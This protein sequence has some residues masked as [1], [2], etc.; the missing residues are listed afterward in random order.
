MAS[1]A[2]KRTKRKP[3][4]SVLVFLDGGDFFL[5][6]GESAE[7]DGFTRGGLLLELFF[8]FACFCLVC[9]QKCSVLDLKSKHYNKNR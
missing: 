3:L 2:Q 4:G 5:G 9:F 1:D 7:K 6:G 8:V